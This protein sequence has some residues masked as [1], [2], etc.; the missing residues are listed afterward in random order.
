MN[1]EGAEIDG[2]RGGRNVSRRSHSTSSTVV[3]GISM[4]PSS[5]NMAPRLASSRKRRLP[6]LL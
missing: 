4:T 1:I 5:A 6:A 2:L 3:T